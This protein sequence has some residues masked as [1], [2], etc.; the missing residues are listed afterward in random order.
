ML[1]KSI[2]L[3]LKHLTIRIGLVSLFF[4]VVF[5]LYD[6]RI[7]NSIILG[8]LFSFI[9]FRQFI[10]TQFVMLNQKNKGLFY[11]GFFARIILYAIPLSCGL[12]YKDY[13][14]FVIILITLFAYQISY[15]LMEFFRSYKKYK[16][17]EKLWKD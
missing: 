7:S 4:C 6:P 5:Y 16:R 11:A 17:R 13:F 3:I 12:L 14:N 2:H 1:P 10:K 9:S 15:V 8:V